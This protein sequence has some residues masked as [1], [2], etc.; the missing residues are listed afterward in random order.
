MKTLPDTLEDTLEKLFPDFCKRTDNTLRALDE[1]IVLCDKIKK[2]SEETYNIM[3]NND[4]V[5]KITEI[6]KLILKLNKLY[7]DYDLIMYIGEVK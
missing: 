5:D 1:G 4:R 7:S 6:M 2:L 3:G